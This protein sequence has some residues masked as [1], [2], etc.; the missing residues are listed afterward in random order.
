MSAKGI[1]KCFLIDANFLVAYVH[2]S[3]SDDDRSRIEHLF[4][5]AEKSKSRI[6]I[7]MPAAAEYLVGADMAG[8]ESFNRLERKTFVYVAPFDRASAF[9]CALLDRA[10][11]GGGDKKDGSISPWQKVKIDRQIVAIG[12]AN[13]ATLVISGD[14]GVRN[15]ALRVGMDAKRVQDLELPE[16]AKQAKLE[17]VVTNK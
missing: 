14:E 9:E 11:L 1:H 8:V 15:N 3:T 16:S 7:P 4:S 13:G 12:K 6:I 5:L 2:P 10:A 17:L